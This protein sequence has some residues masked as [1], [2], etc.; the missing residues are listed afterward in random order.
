MY[1][2]TQYTVNVSH[3]RTP[4]P[5][6]RR[7]LCRSCA[8]RLPE[9]A[10]HAPSSRTPTSLQRPVKDAASNRCGITCRP[11]Q[12]RPRSGPR[13]HRL[14]LFT[15]APTPSKRE[16]F[17]CEPL[18]QLRHSVR[19]Q[20]QGCRSRTTASEAACGYAWKSVGFCSDSLRLV[21]SGLVPEMPIQAKGILH[22][23]HN[24]VNHEPNAEAD[25]CAVQGA[26]A[27]AG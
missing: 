19:V 17:F 9:R 6:R 12:S 24:T 23:A 26:V 21:V 20:F 18:T 1:V 15:H 5:R 11:S 25:R 10:R 7:I 13:A 27:L 16:R 4:R 2:R 3:G 8:C 14:H 22:D